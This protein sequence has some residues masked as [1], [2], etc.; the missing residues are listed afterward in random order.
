MPE[1][2]G[3]FA[4]ACE[5]VFFGSGFLEVVE[6]LLEFILING[7]ILGTASAEEKNTQD[8]MGKQEA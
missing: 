6:F 2:R 8:S 7:F 3:L 1:G 4:F 5:G